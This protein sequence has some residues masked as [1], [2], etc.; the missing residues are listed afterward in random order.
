MLT[1]TGVVTEFGYRLDLRSK[2][3]LDSWPF[4]SANWARVNYI[5][6]PDLTSR[7]RLYLERETH[8]GSAALARVLNFDF[9]TAAE[10]PGFIHNFRK[11]YRHYPASTAVEQ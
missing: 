1:L 11:Y 3:G 10:M 2:L 8:L 4:A 7:E 9:E 6:V 5:A